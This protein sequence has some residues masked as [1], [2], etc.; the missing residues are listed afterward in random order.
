LA[1]RATLTLVAAVADAPAG[2]GQ[3]R[4]AQA[5]KRADVARIGVI[6]ADE[7]H[8]NLQEVIKRYVLGPF[9]LDPARG[10]LALCGEPL[11]L[12]PRVVATLTALV[13]RAGEVV[14]KDEMLDRVWAGED[15]GESNVAQSVYTLRKVLR[16]HGLADAIVTIPRRG[17]RLTAP[18]Q[19]RCG[20]ADVTIPVRR[21]PIAPPRTLAVRW[22][23]AAF[24]V[25]LVFLAAVPAARAVPHAPPLSARGAELY[26][27]G[28]YYWNLRSPAGLAKSAR[29]FA[30]VTA[31]DP[32]SPLGHAG[33]A[34]VD[35]MLADYQVGP[36]KPARY[37]ARARSEI[38]RALALD[39]E[40][41]VAHASLGMLRF[42]ADH[43]MRGAE[44]EFRHATALDPGYAVAHH[45][46]GTTLMQEGRVADAL[47]ELGLAMT[48]E[49]VAP[50]TGS[51]LAE[52]SYFGGR[53]ADA[54]AYSRR[55][56]DL[57]PHRDGAL[58]RLG[59]A[60]ELAGDLPRAI[61]AFER[62]RRSGSEGSAAPALLAEAY[63]RS[64]RPAAARAALRE[65]LR[66]HPRDADTAFALLALGE[67]RRGLTILARRPDTMYRTP[68]LQ[69]P[70]LAPFRSALRT[71]TARTTPS[72]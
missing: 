60:Y 66:L 64:G 44:S 46:Y 50:A 15:V 6:V 16:D 69:D 59:L 3:Q 23:T 55:A 25:V 42:T 20:P 10:V 26:R 40:S 22:L 24:S 48:L 7:A 17:Y 38:R 28:R 4:S 33:L 31:S 49:P 18:V 37:L 57:D 70:R 11:P 35:L 19:L 67:R 47:H 51:W 39:R 71:L 1:A 5:T 29:L 45:W 72:S 34:D 58:R 53:Y 43:D 8:P 9:E 63:A 30:A 68:P 56:L 14:T 2:A 61:A 54:I 52:A 41:A 32:R 62:L 27:L 36:L 65:A 21:E 13:E 12:G